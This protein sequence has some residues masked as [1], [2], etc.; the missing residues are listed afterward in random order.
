[1]ADGAISWVSRR[2]PTISLSST[3]AEYKAASDN[4]RQMAWL[5]TFASELGYDMNFATPLYLDNQGAIFLSVNPVVER[6]T[7]HVEVW[8]HYIREFYEAGHTDIYYVITSDMLADALT[9]NVPLAIQNK[10]CQGVG[11]RL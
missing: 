2:Q 7:K 4:C 3:E 9:K 6:R 10:F 8:Y 1:M 5:R 11:L